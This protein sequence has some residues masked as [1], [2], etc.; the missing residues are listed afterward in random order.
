M[1]GIEPRCGYDRRGLGPRIVVQ[2]LDKPERVVTIE[3]DYVLHALSV[4]MGCD[5]TAPNLVEPLATCIHP[6]D[7]MLSMQRRGVR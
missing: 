4:A 7:K 3:H 6:I 5:K 2:G 1:S